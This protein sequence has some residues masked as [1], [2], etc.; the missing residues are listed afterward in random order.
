[1]KIFNQYKAPEFNP[2]YLAVEIEPDAFAA[3]V[4]AEVRVPL[5]VPSAFLRVLQIVVV[6]AHR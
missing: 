5:A 3:G 2:I 1:M 4:H 6:A